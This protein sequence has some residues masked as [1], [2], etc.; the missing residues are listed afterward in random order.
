MIKHLDY[1]RSYHDNVETITV[2]YANSW[3]RKLLDLKE[4]QEVYISDILEMCWYNVDN[5]KRA[6]R[7]IERT[8]E[9]FAQSKRRE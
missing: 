7:Y 2:T 1:L 3:I 4:I 9:A 8:L 5:G 6:A